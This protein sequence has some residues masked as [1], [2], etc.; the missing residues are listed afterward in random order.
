[1][2]DAITYK[3]VSKYETTVSFTVSARQAKEIARELMLIGNLDNTGPRPYLTW[4]YP[5][6][7]FILCAVSAHLREAQR[8]QQYWFD[9]GVLIGLS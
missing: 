7:I 3:P 6:S 5:D 9:E 2:S 1:M 4:R 8:A